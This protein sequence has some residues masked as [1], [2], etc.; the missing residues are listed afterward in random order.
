MTTVPPTAGLPLRAAD[1]WP[2]GDADLASA[3]ARHLGLP[4]AQLECSGTA[5]LVMAL[6]AL[7]RLAPGRCEVIVPAYTCPLVALAV[8]H[9]GLQLRLCDLQADALDLDPAHL[10]ALAGARTLAIVPT[11]LGGRVADVQAALACARRVGAWV[12]EDAAQSLGARVAGAPVGLQGDLGFYSLAVGKGLTLYE[13]G[14][15]FAREDALRAPVH[16]ASIA[17]APPRLWMELRRSLELLGYAALY[18]PAGLGWAYGAPLR[19]ALA[20]GDWEQAAG[21]DFAPTIPLHRPGRWRRA[22]GVRALARLADFQRQA[23]LRAAE[24]LPRLAA[25]PGVE[26]V[27]DSPAVARA[28]GVWPVLLVR[29]PTRAVRDAVLRQ[30]WG[31]GWGLGVPFVQALPDYRRYAAVVPPVPAQALPHAR[32]WA[33]RLLSI[34]NSPWLD[35]AHFAAVCAALRAAVDQAQPAARTC[36]RACS[37]ASR[38]PT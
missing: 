4:H 12:V 23:A 1:L 32:D 30:H 25:I 11:H 22:V 31:Q 20:R 29:L 15:L 6:T 18:R 17:L 34:S 2:G 10:D 19:R 14:L 5:A 26:P 37:S 24:R 38:T 9:C 28:A 33:G 7:Q 3:L 21:D 13:G 35:E 8:A 36:S 27:G 16:E